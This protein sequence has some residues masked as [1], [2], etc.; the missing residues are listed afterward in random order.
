[1]GAGCGGGAVIDLDA[2]YIVLSTLLLIA[3]AVL[4]GWLVG[5]AAGFRDGARF[6]RAVGRVDGAFAAHKA[7]LSTEPVFAGDRMMRLRIAK[8]IMR[9]SDGYVA[10]LKKEARR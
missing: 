9:V 10:D 4:G 5:H 7:T 6:F 3:L 2:A 8:E 1:M